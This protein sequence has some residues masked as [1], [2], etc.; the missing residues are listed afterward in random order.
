MGLMMLVVMT[1]ADHM[2]ECQSKQSPLPHDQG[3]C[4]DDTASMIQ[5]KMNFKEVKLT[6][7]TEAKV[8]PPLPS[9]PKPALEEEK[10]E[11]YMTDEAKVPP[12]LPSA[13]K[14]AL[15]EEKTEQYM[16]DEAQA[17]P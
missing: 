7:D 11:Q 12:P 13:P 5:S 1:H 2:E 14:P 16:T 8:P 17:P 3:T 15:E 10:T 4:V 9:A 6:D